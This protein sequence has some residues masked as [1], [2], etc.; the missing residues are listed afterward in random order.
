[1]NLKQSRLITLSACETGLSEAMGSRAEE[2]VGLPAG[3]LQA[4]GSAIV[5]SLW[6]VDDLSTA[7]LMERFYA[8]LLPAD[9]NG[10]GEDPDTRSPLPPAE[11]LR[12]AQIWLRDSVTGKQVRDYLAQA[13]S[14]GY[15]EA[16]QAITYRRDYDDYP[17]DA[18][19]FKRPYYW[20][21]FSISGA[22]ATRK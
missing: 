13:L 20:A 1:L 14:K 10:P 19:P 5:A 12:R 4:G 17:D 18:H 16:H 9:H 7:L 22:E 2:Y 6:A 21:A 8:N 3:F 15:I 11:A